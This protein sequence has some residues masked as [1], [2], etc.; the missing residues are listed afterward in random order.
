MS[1]H[2]VLYAP[3]TFPSESTPLHFPHR[4]T[5]DR[6]LH[7]FAIRQYRSSREQPER[8]SHLEA[9]GISRCQG[10]ASYRILMFSYQRTR[11]SVYSRFTHV[12]R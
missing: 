12:R 5:Q 9:L 3:K 10:R 4:V 6:S 1:L 7:H 11:E 8:V 2:N